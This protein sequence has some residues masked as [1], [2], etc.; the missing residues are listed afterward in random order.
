MLI[1]VVSSNNGQGY[2]LSCRKHDGSDF[3][4]VKYKDGFK[5]EFIRP[6]NGK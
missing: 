4:T 5:H 3:C 1:I 2:K 6:K